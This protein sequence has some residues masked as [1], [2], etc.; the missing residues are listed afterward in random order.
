MLMTNWLRENRQTVIRGLGSILALAL[1]IV[2]VQEEGDGQLFSALRRVS[3]GYFLAAVVAL[4]TS[5]LFAATR[6][7]IL[8]KSAC[9]EIPFLR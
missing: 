9:V 6:W 5:R 1:L 2:L 7:H 3:I 8:L 4:T